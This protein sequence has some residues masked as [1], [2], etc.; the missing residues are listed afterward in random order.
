[1]Q[2]KINGIKPVWDE[3]LK[4][5]KH[6]EMCIYLIPQTNVFKI[7]NL[8]PKI[9]NQIKETQKKYEEQF[10]RT[11]QVSQTNPIFNK[12]TIEKVNDEKK[13]LLG[14]GYDYT[15]TGNWTATEKTTI[16]ENITW[17][18][19]SETI[20]EKPIKSNNFLIG[21]IDAQINI[22]GI[23][24]FTQT[25]TVKEFIKKD[26]V[27]QLWSATSE[28][29]SHKINFENKDLISESSK[30]INLTNN[31]Q[32]ILCSLFVEVKPNITSIGEVLRQINTYYSYLGGYQIQKHNLVLFTTKKETKEIFNSQD[33]SFVSIEELDPQPKQLSVGDF[34]E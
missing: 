28:P 31:R 29:S 33:I 19:K 21:V 4:T 26:C 2:P 27:E 3:Q 8:I 32:V 23:P 15:A 24:T 13:K 25:V 34:N 17:E 12:I 9:A 30:S 7:I 14:F 10:Q 1:M 22:I 6:D 16:L 20:L 18:I 5:P 11:P